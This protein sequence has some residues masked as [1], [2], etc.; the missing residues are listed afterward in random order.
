[1]SANGPIT[2]LGAARPEPTIS[3]QEAPAMSTRSRPFLLDVPLGLLIGLV[4]LGMARAAGSVTGNGQGG[5]PPWMQQRP[6]WTQPPWTRPGTGQHPM[7]FPD[8]VVLGEPYTWSAL[9][10]V[11]IIAI[12]IAV[13]RIRP[14]TGYGMTVVGATGYLSVG[15]PFGPVL[16]APALGLL[17]LATRLPVRRWVPWA[18]LLLPLI[19]AGFVGDRYLGFANP[20]LYT[21]LILGPPLIMV[22]AL[23]A[24]IRRIRTEESKR[25]HDLEVRRAAYQERLRIARDV[26]DLIGHSLSV[27]NMQAGVALYLLDKDRQKARTA[28]DSPNADAS[29]GR[30]EDS[31]Q[32]IRSTSKNALDELRATLAVFRGET[33]DER[34]P[35]SGL[36]RLPELVDSFRSAGRSVSVRTEGRFDDLPGPVDNAAYRVLQEALTNVA[37]HAGGADAELSISRTTDR[38]VVD[39]TDNGPGLSWSARDGNGS[40]HQQTKGSGL[41]GMKERALAV[42][43][44]VTAGPRV[45]G[46]F[47]VHAEFPIRTEGRR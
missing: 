21:A 1:M 40:E 34:A 41:I 16:V 43:G 5:Q 44:D 38:L 37:R 6:P 7:Q 28:S 2:R 31:L 15:L 36:A 22:P 39:V 29:G 8:A 32:A 10:W 47:A 17:A 9:L 30:V 3:E 35:V 18:G 24:T 12:G 11:L 14:L 45:G 4:C 33:T 27:I 25:A 26:H 13:R 20:D 42:G 19:W 23:I 46:G